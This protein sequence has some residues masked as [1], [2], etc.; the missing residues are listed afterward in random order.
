MKQLKHYLLTATCFLSALSI[1]ITPQTLASSSIEFSSLQSLSPGS[2]TTSQKR[3][4]NSTDSAP[5][6][7]EFSFLIKDF[8]L[9][10]QS[11]IN[12]LNI[13]VRYRYAA[14]ISNAEYPDFRLIAK[15]IEELLNNYPNEKDYWEILNKKITLMVLEKFPPIVRVTSEI[16]VSPS[17]LVPY[18][19]S[20]IVT[21][22]RPIVRA[23]NK[24]SMCGK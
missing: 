7:E 24:K 23:G 8:K 5:L 11:E 2:K 10:H 15:A 9:N 14:N 4:S 21:R 17:A 6:I 13:T 22:N 1:L 12:N 16:Q 3:S 18:F 20:S 19:R